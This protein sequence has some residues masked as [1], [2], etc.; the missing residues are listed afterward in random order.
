M[1]CTRMGIPL[2]YIPTGEGWRYGAQE[3]LSFACS[4]RQ[5]LRRDDRDASVCF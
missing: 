2:R 5:I 4:A 1:P 3:V